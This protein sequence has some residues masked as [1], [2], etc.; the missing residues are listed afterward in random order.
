MA[1]PPTWGQ[2]WVPG[3]ALLAA[4]FGVYTIILFLVTAATVVRLRETRGMDLSSME[5]T[6]GQNRPRPTNPTAGSWISSGRAGGLL[7]A[8]DEHL[9][10]KG[11]VHAEPR[12]KGHR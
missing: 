12:G 7:C 1:Q 11:A 9:V 8:V 5:R 10:L 6:S 4:Y 2:E 3:S